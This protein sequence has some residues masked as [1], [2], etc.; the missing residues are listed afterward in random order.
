MVITL[1]VSWVII[2]QNYIKNVLVALSIQHIKMFRI[3]AERQQSLDLLFTLISH[4]G[5]KFG[6]IGCIWVSVHFQNQ[7]H[8]FI[9]S[10]LSAMSLL[11]S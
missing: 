5:D 2:E 3:I 4:V 6:I 10:M 1:F 9:V 11:I 8:A 7:A